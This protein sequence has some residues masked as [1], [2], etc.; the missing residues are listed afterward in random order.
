MRLG[1][2]TGMEE[3]KQ[4]VNL[5]CETAIKSKRRGFRQERAVSLTQSLEADRVLG[6]AE[7]GIRSYSC[8]IGLVW[9]SP[10]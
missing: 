6:P 5:N 3:V 2:G 4:A 9:K 7:N 1:K 8:G 10:G